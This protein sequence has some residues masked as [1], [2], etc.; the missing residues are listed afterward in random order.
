[1]PAQSRMPVPADVAEA[2]IAEAG[3]TLRLAAVKEKARAR[4]SDRAAGRRQ[5]KREER[6]RGAAAA[7]GRRRAKEDRLLAKAE[8]AREAL[9]ARASQLA[10]AAGGSVLACFAAVPDPRGRRG[11]RHPLPCVLGLVLTAMLHGKTKLS[12]ITAWISAADQEI[13]AALGART[14]GNGLRVPPCARTVAR[15]LALLGAQLLADAAAAY[16][17]AAELAAAPACPVA[18]PVL[19]PSLHCDGKE[20]R[21]AVRPDGTS[22]FLLSAETGG[23]VLA[24]RE[25]AAKTNEITQ[26]GPM[27]LALNVLFPLAGWII[28]ADALRTQRKLAALACEDLPARYVFTVKSSQPDLLSALERPC[29]A[30]ARRHATAG[31]GH[32]RRET[33]WTGNGKKWARVT[34]TTTGT[35]CLITSL[36]AREA[37]PEHI[38]ACIRGHRAAESKIHWVRDDTFRE[39]SARVRADSRPRALATLRNLAMGLIRQAGHDDIAATI[40]AAEH[41]STLLRALLRLTPAT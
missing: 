16:L 27:L 4:R 11:R 33:R 21:G 12:G 7:A 22:P 5:A 37:G 24:E 28:T 35:V 34:K 40:R 18:G 14:G 30:G 1:M 31:K 3:E 32:G 41:D 9:Q 23:I 17:A 20:V 2:V 25:I 6:D 13:L 26:I 15:L 19:Q 8:Q 39:D 38:A 36:T 10:G 29:R